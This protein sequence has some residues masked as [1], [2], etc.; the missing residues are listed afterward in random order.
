MD[1]TIVIG[2]SVGVLVLLFALKAFELG[3]N[4]RPWYANIRTRADYVCA[5]G[6][7]MIVH[8]LHDWLWKFGTV[9]WK[10][11]RRII[12]TACARTRDGVEESLITLLKSL[13]RRRQGRKVGN[14]SQFLQHVGEHKSNLRNGIH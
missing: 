12:G 6:G 11:T 7:E 5:R 10:H 13:H 9:A 14:A 4:K 8:A 3:R 1:H 2:I